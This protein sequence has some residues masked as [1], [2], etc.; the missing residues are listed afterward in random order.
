MAAARYSSDVLPIYDPIPNEENRNLP[1][2]NFALRDEFIIYQNNFQEWLRVWRMDTSEENPNKKDLLM[3]AKENKEKFTD[4]VE[5]EIQRL[6]NVKIGFGLDVKFKRE[7]DGEPQPPMEHYF[8]TSKE[9]PYV[10]FKYD[11]VD[12]VEQKFD[13]FIE[14]TKG[15]IEHWCEK[16]SGWEIEK[17]MIAYVNVARYKPLRGGGYLPLPP[18][19]AK[20]KAIINVK[21]RDNECLKW[22]LR[23]ALFLPKDEKDP[24]RPSK[25]PVN[26][27]INYE[28]IDFPT[29]VNQRD[30]LEAQN[31]NLAINVFWLGEK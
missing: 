30:K 3:F 7:R 6:E 17:I 5:Q 10:F 28:G 31:K 16:G 18:K 29:P 22:S 13:E 14:K 27:G 1:K 4:L 19:L 8:R 11:G 26:D 15:E 2:P 9:N 20:K 24:Q 25:Y 23:A 21:N 12:K